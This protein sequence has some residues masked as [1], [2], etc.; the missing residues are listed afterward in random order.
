LDAYLGGQSTPHAA[1]PEL[2]LSQP[3]FALLQ[4]SLG[5]DYQLLRELDG[6]GMSRVFVALDLQLN[7]EV[8]VKV[9]PPDLAAG[10]KTERFKREIQLAARLQHPHIV[11]V[12]S[13]GS[14]D[15]LLYYTMPFVHGPSLA[16]RLK[17]AEP[18]PLIEAVCILRDVADAL[19]F[20]HAEGVIHRDVKPQNILLPGH[21][22]VVL[23]FGVAKALTEAVDDAS[24]TSTGIAL[25]T[26]MYMAPEQAVADPEVDARADIYSLGVVAYE[27]LAGHPPFRARNPQAVM[28]A[29]V[30][31]S[32]QPLD[33]AGPN[34]PPALAAIVMRCLEKNPA[35]RWQ[36]TEELCEA[37]NDVGARFTPTRRL[38]P[39]SGDAVVDKTVGTV[40]IAASPDT[41]KRIQLRAVV[42]A[43]AVLLVAGAGAIYGISS[44]RAADAKPQSLL[45]LPFANDG[46]KDVDFF[47]HGM[48]QEVITSLV[49]VDGLYVASPTS[50]FAFQENKVDPQSAGKR[51]GVQY[52]L[53]GAIRRDGERV[54]ITTQLLSV[55][56][57][58]Y[59]WSN[60]YDASL[61]QV[62]DVQASI[63]ADIAQALTDKLIIRGG[64]RLANQQPTSIAAYDLYLKGNFVADSDFSAEGLTKAIEFYDRALAIDPGYARA[65]SGI[66]TAYYNLADDFWEPRRAY[67]RVRENAIRA[68]KLDP[69]LA[70][71][72]ASLASYEI[73]YGWDWESAREN[74]Q[75]AV[76][77]NP[78]N[79]FAR[80][81]LAWYYLILNRENEAVT[82]AQKARALDPYSYSIGSSAVSLLRA[83]GRHEL[84][85]HEAR[86]LLSVA[87][88]DTSVLR[89]WM[90][91]DYMLAGK[92]DSARLQLDSAVKRNP[93]CCLRT[94]ALFLAHS[95]KRSQAREKLKAWVARKR[96]GGVY[97]RPDWIAEVEAALANPDGS[98]AALDEALKVRSLGVPL[99]DHNPELRRYRNDPRFLSLKKNVGL[100]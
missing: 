53:L 58:R 66:S 97:F 8:V 65:Y 73:A 44:R 1:Y 11:P 64:Q 100:H 41:R 33:E 79:S 28:A 45:V 72:Y 17:E 59:T 25:G 6:A 34:I 83:A 93:S 40:H 7:R 84:A 2:P 12:L 75:R 43:L 62:F 19:T 86:R 98:F 60:S 42:A 74:A 5:R 23:D 88:G 4:E 35:N 36:S 78:N 90:S 32:P 89:A 20:A 61:E 91:W 29:H 27:I 15:G 24:L 81:M 39:H 99:V 95:G 54:R 38:T 85:I 13:A 68:L 16:A 26:P 87:V 31:T 50:S 21:H 48:T 96:A 22:A 82:E 55:S 37:L 56:S 71:A 80:I 67:P 49:K 51:V 92:L 10:I 18:I 47:V 30:T 63:S 77:L 9:L 70:D 69:N 46:G 94:E 76:E 57:G 14:H 52:V 3:L